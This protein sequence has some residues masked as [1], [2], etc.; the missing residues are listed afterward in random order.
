MSNSPA[1]VVN[2][3]TTRPDRTLTTDTPSSSI[4]SLFQALF[5]AELLDSGNQIWVALPRIWNVPVIDNRSNAFHHLEPTWPQAKVRLVSILKKMI[6]SG[7]QVRILTQDHSSNE[8]FV[9]ELRGTAKS[10]KRVGVKTADQWSAVT[11]GIVASSFFVSGGLNLS[12]NGFSVDDEDVHLYTSKS[13]VQDAFSV[14]RDQW[15]QY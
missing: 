9:G 10:G 2:D 6:R 11:P 5:A 12:K 8:T 4:E 3:Q 13:A 15:A 7:V 1:D 14:F